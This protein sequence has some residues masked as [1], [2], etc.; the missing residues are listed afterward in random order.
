MSNQT[1]EHKTQANY[2]I[3]RIWRVS[4]ESHPP[5]QASMRPYLKPTSYDIMAQVNRH[6]I[7]FC[8][9]LQLAVDSAIPLLSHTLPTVSHQINVYTTHLD[10][11]RRGMDNKQA[12]KHKQKQQQ[13]W[14]RQK[15]WQLR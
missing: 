3:L 2:S 4:N 6:C 5:T 7:N 11:Q 8:T 10:Q 12:N 15:Q 13:Q 14:Q 1:P 9:A